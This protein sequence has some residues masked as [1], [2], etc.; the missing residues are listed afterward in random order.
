MHDSFT[1]TGSKSVHA[2]VV[3]PPTGPSEAL[4]VLVPGLG[5]L[6][7]ALPTAH[8]L[9]RRGLSTR[10]LDLPGFGLPTPDSTRPNIHAI[11][12]MTAAWVRQQAVGRPVVIIGHSTGSQA[13][14]TGA[15]AAQEFHDD[16]ALVMAGPTFVPAQRRWPRLLLATLTAY[17]DDTLRQLRPSEI[18]RGWHGVPEIL[19]SGL[20]DAVD[21]RLPR[22][23]VPLHLTSGE[24]DSFAPAA[25]LTRLAAVAGAS[26]WVRTTTLPG[27][28]N[29]L[30]THPDAVA[31]VIAVTREALASGRQE[32]A[33]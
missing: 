13:A 5:L 4:V 6:K 21:Q 25:W 30:Y 15:L 22:L 19:L 33:A 18:A 1:D 31:D 20:D 3:D 9:A 16:L 27:S 26:P 11:G 2:V 12:L 32:P 7:Y 10:L 17:R 23:R 8:A 28:H 14:L 29:N 24:H